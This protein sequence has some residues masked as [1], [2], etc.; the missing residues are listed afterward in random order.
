LQ[1]FVCV[2]YLTLL[3]QFFF[4]LVDLDL[5]TYAAGF[6]LHLYSLL[7][8]LLLFSII[9]VPRRIFSKLGGIIYA[10]IG[11]FVVVIIFPIK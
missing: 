7:W 1:T 4:I 11:V 9:I 10:Y 2:F 8:L 5:L 6:L 3:H